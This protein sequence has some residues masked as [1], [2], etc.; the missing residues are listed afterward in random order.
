[1]LKTLAYSSIGLRT[2]VKDGV[3]YT[4]SYLIE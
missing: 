3:A 2:V 1:M 4:T